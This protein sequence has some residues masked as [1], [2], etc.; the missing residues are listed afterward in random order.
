MPYTEW[1]NITS[2]VMVLTLTKNMVIDIMTEWN[3]FN[4]WWFLCIR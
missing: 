4:F 1:K 3:H 2:V